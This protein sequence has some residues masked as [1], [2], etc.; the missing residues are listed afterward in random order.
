M[1]PSPPP[2]PARLLASQ[3]Q[4]PSSSSRTPTLTASSRHVGSP[5]NSGLF[6]ESWRRDGER[7]PGV[8][9]GSPHFSSLLSPDLMNRTPVPTSPEVL[10]P[11]RLD[12]SG[13]RALLEQPDEQPPP[14]PRR[15]TAEVPSPQLIE[16][17]RTDYFSQLD[18]QLG[19]FTRQLEIQCEIQKKELRTKA[20]VRKQAFNLQVDLQ[21]QEQFSLVQQD[22]DELLQR[23]EDAA[24][25][26]REL[27]E[28]RAKAKLLDYEFNYQQDIEQ[29]RRSVKLQPGLLGTPSAEFLVPSQLPRWNELAVTESPKGPSQRDSIQQACV[30]NG[31]LTNSRDFPIPPPPPAPPPAAPPVPPPAPPLARPASGAPPP[32]TQTSLQLPPH[33][34]LY[35]YG[36]FNPNALSPKNQLQ[37]YLMPPNSS[38]T[39]SKLSS[40]HS[41]TFLLPPP[42]PSQNGA[43]PHAYPQSSSAVTKFPSRA[44]SEAASHQQ[45][46]VASGPCASRRPVSEASLPSRPPSQLQSPDLSPA[47]S[48]TSRASAMKPKPLERSP[49]NV[50]AFFDH[51]SNKNPFKALYEHINPPDDLA[52]E[53]AR[54]EGQ[55]QNHGSAAEAS[56]PLQARGTY[57]LARG[58]RPLPAKSSSPQSKAVTD[59]R[60]FWSSTRDPPPPLNW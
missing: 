52:E 57:P 48:G 32:P 19:Q 20:N 9:L 49:M 34:G 2:A 26:Q 6:S 45:S 58:Q 54:L 15:L 21:L 4:F 42:P 28:R 23:L 18:L 43:R 29:S 35:D 40:L 41:H 56:S 33:S 47:R 13:L 12:D 37:G 36:T 14:R 7:D 44:F 53:Y 25:Q 16:Q 39:S 5:P 3:A 24:R 17:H 59:N 10:E 1:L 30:S 50:S 27:L 11:L 51:V 31:G 8:S 38:R 22:R 60:D 46:P 55:S